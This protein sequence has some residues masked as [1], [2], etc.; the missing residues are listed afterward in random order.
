MIMYRGYFT[1]TLI[2]MYL[3]VYMREVRQ[4]LTPG[5]GACGSP[6]V[7]VR[8]VRMR[9]NVNPLALQGIVHRPLT[10]TKRL[11]FMYSK[12]IVTR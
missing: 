12:S 11:R 4:L 2:V 1:F 9:S 7:E 10:L 8:V 6:W 5:H 3:L